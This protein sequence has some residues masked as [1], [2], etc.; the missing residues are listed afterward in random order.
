M[1]KKL[2]LA[3]VVSMLAAMMSSGVAS[4]RVHAITPLIDNTKDNAAKSGGIATFGTPAHFVNG[5]PLAMGP[6]PIATGN[7]GLSEDDGGRFALTDNPI[8]DP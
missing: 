7:S 3:V 5:G 1:K 2:L 6:I 8:H 4:A